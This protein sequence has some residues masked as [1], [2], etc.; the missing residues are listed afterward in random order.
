MR[1]DVA[2]LIAATGKTIYPMHIGSAINTDNLYKKSIPIKS[3]SRMNLLRLLLFYCILI[4][5]LNR[6][7]F[8]LENVC[9]YS[10]LISYDYPPVVDIYQ[11]RRIFR[12]SAERPAWRKTDREIS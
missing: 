9:T 11:Q 4:K 7:D 10:K 3:N 6:I 12:H 1:K 5:V 2:N 8:L